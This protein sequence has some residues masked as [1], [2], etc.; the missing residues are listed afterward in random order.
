MA[1]FYKDLQVISVSSINGKTTGATTIFTTENGARAFHPLII[2]IECTAAS[3][4]TVPLSLSIGT[5][6]ATFNNIVAITAA[7]GLTATAT[8]FP[9]HLAVS[10]A[11]VPANTGVSLN[12]TTAATGTSQT[13]AVHIVGFYS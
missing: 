2:V 1:L 4:I 5:N 11:V 8:Q 3:A 7:T 9:I 6:S 10:T 12:I 13:I